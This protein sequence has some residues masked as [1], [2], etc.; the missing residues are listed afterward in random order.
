MLRRLFGAHTASRTSAGPY[1]ASNPPSY[2]YK[3]VPT[4]A[5]NP[6]YVFP[7]PIPA[8][9]EFVLSE[10]DAKDGFIHLSTA[11]QIHQV[12]SRFFSSEESVMLLKIDYARLIGFKI[13]KWEAGGS[14][15]EVYPHLYRTLE[16]EYVES[17]EE[18]R[19]GEEG[20]KGWEGGLEELEKKGWLE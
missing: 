9:H 15:G 8:S 13:V 1:S 10:L 19:K 2:V 18:V 11:P 3:I 16:G 12:L 14:Q 20:E 4:A 6:R 7:I 5:S 17:V